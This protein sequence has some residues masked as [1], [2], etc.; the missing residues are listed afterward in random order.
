M[1][2]DDW[3]DEYDYEENPTN[4][5]LVRAALR[6]QSWRHRLRSKA[7]EV[8]A[9]WR[10]DNLDIDWTGFAMTKGAF[11]C[12]YDFF[13]GFMNPMPATYDI[14]VVKADEMTAEGGWCPPPPK[15]EWAPWATYF[16]PLG[17]FTLRAFFPQ[18]NV[19]RGGVRYVQLPSDGGEA[20]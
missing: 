18:F 17:P 4:D 8:R 10:D 5:R 11:G 6:F 15:M 20:G 19:E 13:S 1:N 14:K 2:D 12:G 3:D 9:I 16:P 7:E